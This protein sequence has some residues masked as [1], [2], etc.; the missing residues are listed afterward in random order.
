MGARSLSGLLGRW[1]NRTPMVAPPC[2]R[3]RLGGNVTQGEAPIG[4]ASAISIFL[5]A[6][7]Y[8]KALLGEMEVAAFPENRRRRA[9]TAATPLIRG[10][11]P[12]P[13]PLNADLSPRYRRAYFRFAYS[14]APLKSSKITVSLPTVQASCPG[15]VISRD[16]RARSRGWWD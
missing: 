3:Q 5:I 6:A 14:G 12:G 16:R 11:C 7:A 4:A 9:G 15:G 8:R 1:S 10:S 13:T 2:S